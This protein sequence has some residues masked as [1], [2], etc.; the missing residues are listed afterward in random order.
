MADEGKKS[1]NQVTPEGAV[2]I[3][4]QDLD[5]ASGGLLPGTQSLKITAVDL[6]LG[7]AGAGPGGGPHVRGGTTELQ[8]FN[9]TKKI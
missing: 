3:D 1:D 2:E 7:V 5:A 4:E 8:D 9:L 6:K